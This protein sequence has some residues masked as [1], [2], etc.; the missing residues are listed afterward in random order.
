MICLKIC[1]PIKA[2][3]LFVHTL[4]WRCYDFRPVD[5]QEKDLGEWDGFKIDFEETE[6]FKIDDED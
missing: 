3:V 2:I 6:E 1:S 5:L 4:R